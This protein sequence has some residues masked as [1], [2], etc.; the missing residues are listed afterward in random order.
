MEQVVYDIYKV[1]LHPISVLM[2]CAACFWFAANHRNFFSV[3]II[4]SLIKVVDVLANKL[5]LGPNWV[6][7]YSFYIALDFITVLCLVFREAITNRFFVRVVYQRI[8]AEYVL[9]GIYVLSILYNIP[10][11]IEQWTRK[12][13]YIL[14]FLYSQ[15]LTS[16]PMFFYDHYVMFKGALGT[17]EHFIIVFLAYQS[18]KISQAKLRRQ[19]KDGV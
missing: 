9:I 4:M 17:F 7:Y 13:P 1:F 10:T 16:P 3:L 2:I 11:F 6:A 18:A 14:N 12:T 8:F 19:A 5:L 15:G